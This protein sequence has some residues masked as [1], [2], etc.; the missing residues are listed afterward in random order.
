MVKYK[1]FP[2]E[3]KRGQKKQFKK[4][5]KEYA[6]LAE[7]IGLFPSVMIS[8]SDIGLIVGGSEIRRKFVDSVICQYSKTY[9]DNLVNY[10]RVLSQRNSLLKY[11][12][13]GARFDQVSLDVWNRQ[14]IPLGEA[15]HK[16]RSSFLKEFVA[17]FQEH[18]N[19]IS[20][21][22]ERVELIYDSQLNDGSFSDILEA[23]LSK[24]RVLNY[25]TAGIHKDDLTFQLNDFPV[26]KFGSQGQQ[27]SYLIALKL[28]QFEFIKGIKKVDPL[29]LLDDVFDKLDSNRVKKMMELISQEHFG[30]IFITDTNQE[31][32]FKIFEDIEIG[33]KYFEIS[34]GVV[35]NEAIK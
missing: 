17:R 33:Q 19:F 28:A 6:K 8:P 9:L 21:E 24:D 3:S 14:L 30:Q 1:L 27:K 4:N 18:Y 35:V 11:F 2:A 32:L 31:R 13:K 20:M 12:S 23:G 5:K 34:E 22:K 7:H 26:K 10:N 15:I 16:E 29:L 25:T